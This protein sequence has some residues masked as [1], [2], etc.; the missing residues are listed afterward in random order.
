[1]CAR[2]NSHSFY[3]SYLVSRSQQQQGRQQ[4]RGFRNSSDTAARKG[5]ENV[6]SF[7]G[8]DRK[9]SEITAKK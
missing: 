1:M 6:K 8:R 3:C 5:H 2:T 9:L 4:H 7:A